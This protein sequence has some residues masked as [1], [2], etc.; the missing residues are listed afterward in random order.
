MIISTVIAQEAQDSLPGFESGHSSGFGGGLD[1]DM[2]VSLSGSPS[3]AGRRSRVEDRLDP[4]MDP[5]L[6]NAT[7]GSA[8]RRDMD[9]GTQA[10]GRPKLRRIRFKSLLHELLAEYDHVTCDAKDH[11][12]EDSPLASATVPIER[13]LRDDVATIGSVTLKVEDDEDEK[14]DA[15]VHDITFSK[16]QTSRFS[17]FGESALLALQSIET[18][19]Q[20]E[21]V[22]GY[23][24]G[25]FQL[26]PLWENSDLSPMMKQALEGQIMAN[27]GSPKLITM[28][29][30][31]IND[32]LRESE[33]SSWPETNFSRCCNGLRTPTSQ[34]RM[35]WDITGL[36]VL[37]WDVIMIPLQVFDPPEIDAFTLGDV[38]TLSYWT[39]D[40]GFNFILGYVSKNGD[41]VF[42]FRNCAEIHER[43]V[44]ARRYHHFCRHIFHAAQI[45]R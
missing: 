11:R 12:A 36:M 6:Q 22:D 27:N 29:T 30:A 21:D 25:L 39:V 45:D 34:F 8:L 38:L 33:A 43:L 1:R 13:L 24:D 7:D 2:S 23:G 18:T 28:R 9:M 5:W 31:Q 35:I 4:V 37:L 41:L 40:L 19:E 15:L 10:T 17:H 16:R 20:M 3:I 42:E 14:E 32:I 44:L 26:I